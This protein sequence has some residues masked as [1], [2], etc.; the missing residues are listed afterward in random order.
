M[1]T[2]PRCG[3]D[4][5]VTVEHE[6]LAD[7]EPGCPTSHAHCQNCDHGLCCGAC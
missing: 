1:S 2:C 7:H 6:D 5:A 3:E 4:D